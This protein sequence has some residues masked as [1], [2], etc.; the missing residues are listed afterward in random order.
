MLSI[1]VVCNCWETYPAVF[2]HYFSVHVSNEHVQGTFPF[3]RED[4]RV[5][6]GFFAINDC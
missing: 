1:D 2:R 5:E 4:G 6:S 3:L